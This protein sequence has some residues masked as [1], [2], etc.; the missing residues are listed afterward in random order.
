[1]KKSVLTFC[2]QFRFVSIKFYLT[3]TADENSKT[4]VKQHFKDKMLFRGVRENLMKPISS[5]MLKQTSKD[6][7]MTVRTTSYAIGFGSIARFLKRVLLKQW[8]QYLAYNSCCLISNI[9]NK[10][11]G[12]VKRTDC[13]NHVMC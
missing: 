12:K 2:E 4:I 5:S 6:E 7:S 1:M 13:E 10:E 8:K 9:P 11:E 3:L